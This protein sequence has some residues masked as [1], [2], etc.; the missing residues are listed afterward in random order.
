[1]QMTDWISEIITGSF[2]KAVDSIIEGTLN[3]IYEF[4]SQVI[5]QPTEPAKYIQNFDQYLKGVQFFAG[6]LLVIFVIWSVFRQLSGVMYSDEKSMGSYFI[7]ITFAGALIYIL[8]KTVTLV[9]LPINTALIKF[10]GSV[11]I[12]VS[13]I[14]NT[15][16]TV[17]GGIREAKISTVM[18]F[19]LVIAIFVLGIAGAIR[20]IE[21]IIVILV[22]PLV[23]LSV[24][25]NSDGLQVWLRELI[26][27]VFTQTI[28][29]LILQILLSIIGGVENMTLMIILSIG[30]IAVGLRGP[31]ILRQYLYRT[32][33]SSALVSSLGSASRLGMMGMIV[34]R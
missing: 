25:N 12:D 16:Q 14:D 31:Q 6:G 22:S 18:F 26:A 23:A 2:W 29:F 32:G 33:T 30:T 17:W 34:K 13:G 4:L 20:Y 28:H 9:F 10:I 27:I 1:M 8:P 7:H 19:I 24:I 15:M 5:V 11:G 21:T 3:Y